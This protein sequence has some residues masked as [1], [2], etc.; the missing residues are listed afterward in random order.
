[1]AAVESLVVHIQVHLSERSVS[2]TDYSLNLIFYFLGKTNNF[3]K[4][5]CCL[6]FSLLVGNLVGF[7]FFLTISTVAQFSLL[8]LFGAYES[9]TS[10]T[11]T[12][13][14]VNLVCPQRVRWCSASAISPLIVMIAFCP[15]WQ[16]IKMRYFPSIY[17]QLSVV[18][19]SGSE[20][21]NG[22][23]MS[24]SQSVDERFET[25]SVAI[26]RN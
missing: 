21:G 5:V 3:T 16:D 12:T 4:S 8:V 23:T 26:L 6:R 13:T 11:E 19:S 22:Q 25:E 1:M 17:S 18:M 10:E 9:M 20:K 2:V 15:S 14:R 7:S 24:Q